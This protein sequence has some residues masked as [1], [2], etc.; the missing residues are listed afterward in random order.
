[1]KKKTNFDEDNITMSSA[2]GESFS[3]KSDDPN[4][5]CLA[6][7]NKSQDS[8]VVF[9]NKHKVLRFRRNDSLSYK[10]MKNE[11]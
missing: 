10:K 5:I 4:L 9:N 3:Y 2:K 7:L 11:T 1:M 8:I 6:F